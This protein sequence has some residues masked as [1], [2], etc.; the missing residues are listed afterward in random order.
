[1]DGAAEGI[2][3]VR[4]HC[5]GGNVVTAAQVATFSA[6]KG[7]SVPAIPSSRSD[8]GSLSLGGGRASGPR[9]GARSARHRAQGGQLLLQTVSRAMSRAMNT[10]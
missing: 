9:H 3:A 2:G 4:D 8:D 7:L 10:R 1:V 6:R 5:G